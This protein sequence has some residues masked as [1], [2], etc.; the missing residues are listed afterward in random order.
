[1]VT[2]IATKTTLTPKIGVAIETSP[3]S[4]AINVNIRPSTKSDAMMAG[5]QISCQPRNVPPR[6]QK[7]EKMIPDPRLDTHNVVNESAPAS[8]AR[9]MKIN[10]PTNSRLASSGKRRCMWDLFSA[11]SQRIAYRIRRQNW[12]L[13]LVCRLTVPARHQSSDRLRLL[14][15]LENDTDRCGD[16]RCEKHSDHS[17]HDSPKHQCK[18]N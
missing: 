2:S 16:R 3:F 15:S 14:Q 10:A 6:L 11:R 17:P 9:F 18:Q 13:N 12:R 7:I 8:P 1:M 5:C 4:I